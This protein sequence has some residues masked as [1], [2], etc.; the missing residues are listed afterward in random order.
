MQINV[1]IAMKRKSTGPKV[2]GPSLNPRFATYQ[3]SNL[4]K[5]HNL[6]EPQFS[7]M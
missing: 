3:L 5:S 7:Y 6:S 1:T 4:G 2:Q